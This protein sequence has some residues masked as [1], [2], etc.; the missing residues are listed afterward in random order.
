MAEN[1]TICSKPQLIDS[2]SE[3]N[4]KVS[5]FRFITWNIDGLDKNNIYNRTKMICDIVEREKADVVFLQEVISSTE[6]VLRE[7]LKQYSFFSGF[8]NCADYYTLT[9]IS[10]NNVK[11][12]SNQ[13]IK[14]EETSMGRNLIKTRVNMIF[15]DLK[16]I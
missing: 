7:Y 6:S 16:I 15:S 9:L 12:E 10:K 3:T 4:D 2:N 1:K 11:F 5:G 13:I 14:Y 8:M